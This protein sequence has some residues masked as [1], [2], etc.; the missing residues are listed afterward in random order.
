LRLTARGFHRVMRV[1][2]SIADLDKND[3]VERQHIAEAMQYRWLPL[4]S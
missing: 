1:A 4:L 3:T 2:R